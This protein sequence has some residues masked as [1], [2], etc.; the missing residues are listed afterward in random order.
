MASYSRYI[1]FFVILWYV[2]IEL[3]NILNLVKQTLF[4]IQW[5]FIHSA[6]L[7]KWQRLNIFCYYYLILNKRFQSFAIYISFEAIKLSRFPP[8]LHVSFLN[9]RIFKQDVIGYKNGNKIT[10]GM[11]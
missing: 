11:W 4:G 6:R 7:Y 8:S 10:Q 3:L 2:A 5:N 1:V 9:L